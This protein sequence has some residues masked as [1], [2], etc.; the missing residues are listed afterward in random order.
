VKNGMPSARAILALYPRMPLLRRALLASRFALLPCRYLHEHTPHDAVVYELGCGQGIL[1]NFL[2]EA[3]PERMVVG[4]DISPARIAVAQSSLG[5][6][7]GIS[8][9]VGDIAD[10]PL[11][12]TVSES[13]RPHVYITSEVLYLMPLERARSVL[14]GIGRRLRPGD[15]YWIIDF[16][17][18][19]CPKRFLLLAESRFLASIVKSGRGLG[20]VFPAFRR[21]TTE[22][23][24]E[25]SAAARLP[26]LG[27][28]NRMLEQAGLCG[29]MEE[30]GKRTV[31]PQVVFRCTPDTAGSRP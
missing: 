26:D 19:S 16:S 9:L 5:R 27:E 21:N 3:A 24:G 13:A 22:A 28:W 15:I 11:T 2:K 20:G 31:F 14:A 17:R 23:F 6:R 7:K 29:R 4:M 30:T 10:L 12:E 18:G 1:A 25:R 8:F